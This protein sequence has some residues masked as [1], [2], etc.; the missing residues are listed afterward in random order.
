MSTG[1]WPK[2]RHDELAA[3]REAGT[4][5]KAIAE[6]VGC[7]EQVASY[8]LKDIEPLSKMLDILPDYDKEILQIPDRPC[9]LT[10]D[11]HAPYFSKLWLRRL[12][13]VCT[14]LGVKDLAIVGD[15]ADMSWISRFVRK[16]QRGGGLDQDARIIYKTLDM[17]LNIFDD[18]WWCFGN[19]EDRLPQRLGGHDML[20]A[21]AEA[22]GRR[23]PGR[24]HVSDIPTLLLGDKWRLEHPKTFSRDGAKVAASAASIYLKNIAC[25]HGHHFGF[26]YDVSGRYLGI[27]L[28]G[29]FDVSKQEYLFKTGI[30]TMPQWQPGFWVYRNGKVLPLED[31]MTDWKDYSVD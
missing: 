28:G 8:H 17:L 16:E 25:A 11:W 18:V 23:T 6:M 30:T 2:E 31:S 19:H 1:V 27:D 26:K 24:L 5:T 20:Q 14:K 29:M 12:I 13:A 21:S 15:F 9:A 4:T 22:V 3:L 10:A 7:S